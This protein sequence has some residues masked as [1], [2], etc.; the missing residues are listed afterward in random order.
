M[1]K[2]PTGISKSNFSSY[3]Y[4]FFFKGVVVVPGALQLKVICGMAFKS[5]YACTHMCNIFCGLEI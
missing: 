5:V 3:P 2:I 4:G 1:A